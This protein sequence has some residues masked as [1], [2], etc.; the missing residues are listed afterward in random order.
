MTT[1]SLQRLAVTLVCAAAALAAARPALADEPARVFEITASRYEF[2]PARIEVEQG[3]RVVVKL[4]STDTDHGFAVKEF[5]V[6]LAVPK[7]GEVVS[8][9][10]VASKAG[11]FRFTCSEYCGSGHARMKGVLVV[12]PKGETR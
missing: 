6:E 1:P 12:K 3:D 8:A 4:R 10:F 5:K 7:S 11:T 2:K 9:E